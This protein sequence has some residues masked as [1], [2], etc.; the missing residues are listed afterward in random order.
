MTF[1]VELWPL[2]E[3][4]VP[5][6]FFPPPRNCSSMKSRIERTL[7]SVVVE[8]PPALLPNVLKK[9]SRFCDARKVPIESDMMNMALSISSLREKKRLPFLVVELKMSSSH[10]CFISRD[11]SLG[12]LVR[13]S[14][15]DLARDSKTV[16]IVLTSSGVKADENDRAANTL[17]LFRLRFVALLLLLL[18]TL[19]F[20]IV[21]HN[22]LIVNDVASVCFLVRLGTDNRR[23]R[24]VAIF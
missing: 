1:R 24:R 17:L 2:A 8:A 16:Q 9:L 10:N 15:D 22:D 4:A 7:S 21:L 11:T 14:T 19:A 6:L 20:F 12:I 5:L 23:T 18:M 3:E 13:D